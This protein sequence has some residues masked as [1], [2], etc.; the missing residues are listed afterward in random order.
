MKRISDGWALLVVSRGVP[1]FPYGSAGKK[2][3]CS[4]GD[5][6]S[7]PEL[8]RF[9]GEGKGYLLQYSVLENSMDYTVTGVTKNQT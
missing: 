5:L 1:A 3:A 7:I 2:S 8:G 9:P 6:D 4:A